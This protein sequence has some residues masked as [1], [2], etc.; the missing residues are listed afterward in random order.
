MS[1]NGESI[2]GGVRHQLQKPKPKDFESNT[3][4]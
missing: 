2:E 3:H 4:N 1:T